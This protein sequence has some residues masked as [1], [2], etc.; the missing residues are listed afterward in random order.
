[1][2]KIFKDPEAKRTFMNLYESMPIP[3]QDKFG[4][5][6][7]EKASQ[8]VERLDDVDDFYITKNDVTDIY[9]ELML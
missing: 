3:D 7:R 2:S 5:M 1:M 9:K 4:K 8:K 6:I